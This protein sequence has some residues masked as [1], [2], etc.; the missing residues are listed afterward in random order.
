MKTYLK[1]TAIA[2]SMDGAGAVV[3]VIIVDAARIIFHYDVFILYTLPLYLVTE[4]LFELM[5]AARSKTN[6]HGK[7]KSRATTSAKLTPLSI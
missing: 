2:A 7:N 4:A 1:S 5:R 6:S 3:V